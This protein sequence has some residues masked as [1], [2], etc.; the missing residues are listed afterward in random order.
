MKKFKILEIFLLVCFMVALYF[1]LPY[2]LSIFGVNSFVVIHASMA[3]H[4]LNQ[5]FFES[6]WKNMSMEPEDLPLRYGFREGDLLITMPS[7]NYRLGDVVVFRTSKSG[8]LS[9]HRIYKLNS[10]HF[11]D[12]GDWCITKRHLEIVNLTKMGMSVDE[13]KDPTSIEAD[14]IYEGPLLEVCTNYWMPISYIKG[15]ALVALP[16]AGLLHIL[17]EGTKYDYH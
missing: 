14:K 15:K 10:T 12:V 11:R 4:R 3:H 17:L 2:V 9:A 7:E 6:F 13:V 8:T 1:M 5:S 16:Q